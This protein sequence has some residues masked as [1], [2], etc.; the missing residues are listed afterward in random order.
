[1]LSRLIVAVRRRWWV[2]A[3][4][5]VAVLI[6][7]SILA[8]ATRLPISSDRVK[9]RVVVALSRALDSDVGLE[10][11]QLRVFPSLRLE[12]GRLTVR[13]KGRTD[14]PPLISIASF[15]V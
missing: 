3:V 12:G 6:A 7:A 10:R 4:L 11:L 14:V 1:M 15:S 5:L 13:H 9:D 2:F 8:V